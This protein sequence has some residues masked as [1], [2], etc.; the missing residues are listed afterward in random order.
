V[1][2]LKP[3][4]LVSNRK[5][6]HSTRE[7]WAESEHLGIVAQLIPCESNN[8][9]DLYTI[10][11]FL[12]FLYNPISRH[13]LSMAEGNKYQ[14]HGSRANV[15]LLKASE[16]S[17]SNE[18]VQTSTAFSTSLLFSS[19]PSPKTQESCTILSQ[20]YLT[21]VHR[22]F[23]LVHPHQR[24]RVK[25]QRSRLAPSAIRRPTRIPPPFLRSSHAVSGCGEVYCIGG[26][27]FRGC[28]SF[29]GQ[30]P[31][32]PRLALH[33]DEWPYFGGSTAAG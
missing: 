10:V 7:Y 2:L 28:S 27:R 23:P 17:S 19:H 20:N 24:F 14:S 30:S 16:A 25:G 31:D 8:Q 32:Q 3:S 11:A 22:L 18:Q 21:R 33:Q 4:S 12:Y 6:E 13:L 15:P 1:L 5:R 26:G 29:N 9:T